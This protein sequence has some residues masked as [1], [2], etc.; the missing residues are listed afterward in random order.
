VN[1]DCWYFNQKVVRGK[2]EQAWRGRVSRRQ[3]GEQV[4]HPAD[5]QDREGTL[6]VLNHLAPMLCLGLRKFFADSAYDDELVVGVLTTCTFSFK[7][8]AAHRVP[9]TLCAS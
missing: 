6:L 3:S 5:I 9:L 8:C 7:L 1:W 2:G 4:V